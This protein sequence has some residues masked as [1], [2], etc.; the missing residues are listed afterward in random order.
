MIILE[1]DLRSQISFFFVNNHSAVTK[2][3]HNN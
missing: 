1:R 2:T 3:W